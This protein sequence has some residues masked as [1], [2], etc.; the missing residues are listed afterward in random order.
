MSCFKLL[1]TLL[2]AATLTMA[3]SHDDPKCCNK[4]RKLTLNFYF[5][6]IQEQ[7]NSSLIISI[8][9]AAPNSTTLEF[10]YKMTEGPEYN[11][12]QIGSFIGFQSVWRQTPDLLFITGTF[13]FT[14]GSY[15]E[16]QGP[17]NLQLPTQRLPVTGGVGFGGLPDD[18]NP[19]IIN[20]IE[21]A[22][23]VQTY[24]LNI[25]E[26]VVTKLYIFTPP[27]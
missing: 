15:F 3:I 23:P 27:V 13:Y 10:N 24:G 7:T 4:P 1:I 5:H 21:I 8:K 6:I 16:I 14:N 26:K 12:K 18:N 22:T 2:L 25:V 9:P 11:S 17:V 20:G 19:A